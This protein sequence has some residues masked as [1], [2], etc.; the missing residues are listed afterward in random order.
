MTS[1]RELL[2]ALKASAPAGGPALC[3]PV[4]NPPSA[5]L[6]PVAT[7]AGKLN[8]ADVRLLTLWRNRF[9]RSF[10]HEFEATEERT[11]RWLTELV[12]S[13]ETRILFMVDELSSRTLGYMG[14][15]FIDWQTKSGEADAIVRGAEAA[16]GLMTAA[17]RTM[18]D[19]AQN[20]LG[21]QT[22]GVRVRSDNSALDFYLRF[23]F[24]EER[25]T[26]LR[27]TA[28]PD[29]RHWVEDP[30]VTPGEPSL[31][32]MILDAPVADAQ[33]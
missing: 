31:V 14:L 11:R 26:S 8:E 23:G 18:L 32:H 17:M 22:L 25:R 4:G 6:R 16:P 28:A 9:V 24:R 33:S 21:L 10:L 7:N 2:I 5:M 3:L 27:A 15:A 13:D 29:G 30:S 12:G 20:Q 1:G 19:W